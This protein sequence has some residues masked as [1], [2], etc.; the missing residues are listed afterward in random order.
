MPIARDGLEHAQPVALGINETDILP[1]AGDIH[2][3]AKHFAAGLGNFLIDSLM[4]STAMTTK[5]YFARL[6]G[7][8]A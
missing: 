1:Y 2:G 3:L 8:F 7:S 4:S 5:G 6:S